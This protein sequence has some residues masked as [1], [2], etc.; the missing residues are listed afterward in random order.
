M[1]SRM[2]GLDG[3]PMEISPEVSRAAIYFLTGS[4]YL[5]FLGQVGQFD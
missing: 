2:R 5:L 3:G 4:R 1:Y